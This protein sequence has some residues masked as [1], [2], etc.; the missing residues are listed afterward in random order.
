M[1]L[2]MEIPGVGFQVF[3]VTCHRSLEREEFTYRSFLTGHTSNSPCVF[4]SNNQVLDEHIVI[5]KQNK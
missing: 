4:L 2:G 1:I 3:I 5:N